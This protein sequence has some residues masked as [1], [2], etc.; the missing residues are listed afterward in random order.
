MKAFISYSHSDE[1]YLE[2]LHVH[3]AQLKR[4]NLVDTWT[5]QAIMAGGKL[6]DSISIAL[7]E[8]DIFIALLSPDYISSN[9]CYNKEFE[10]ALQMQKEGE[11][12][13]IPVVIE[14]CDWLSTPFKEFKALPKDGKPISDWSNINTAFLGV[15]Q[16][17]RNLLDSS[18][19]SKGLINVTKPLSGTAM[20]NYKVKKDFDSIEKIEFV[21]K[22]FKDLKI[23][24]TNNVNEVI[25]LENIKARVLNDSDDSFECVIVNKNKIDTEATLR[26]TRFNGKGTANFQNFYVSE[27]AINWKIESNRG[28]GNQAS[29]NLQFDDYNM[30]WKQASF[31]IHNNQDKALTLKE[32]SDIIWA[33][34]LNSVGIEF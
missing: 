14:P 9:Y 7:N 24:L 15:I 21:E 31:M 17:I 34:W 3:L 28:S 13:I 25:N 32:M 1:F 20:R 27:Y 4:D 19:I 26:L 12:I 10:K 16:E 2:R 33:D 30:F 8:A 6:E 23:Q 22:G 11:L 29:F 18:N 5:D